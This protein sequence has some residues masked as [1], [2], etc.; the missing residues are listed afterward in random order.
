MNTRPPQAPE[1][2]LI[3]LIA[4]HAGQRADVVLGIG[5]DAAL[6]DASAFNGQQIVICTDTLVEGTHFLPGTAPQSLGHKSLAVNLSDLAAMGAEPR[7]ATLSLTLPTA[8]SAWLEQFM[9]GWQTLA[10]SYDLQLLGGDTT[11]GP[12][13][14]T[15]TTIGRVPPGEALMRESAQPGDLILVTGSLGDAAMGLIQRRAA[16]VSDDRL[17]EQL[18]QPQ[19]RVHFACQARAS[20]HACIDVSDGLLADLTHILD[21][22]GCGATVE[23]ENLPISKALGAVAGQRLARDLALTGGD[24]YELCLSCAP[25]QLVRLQDIA[26]SLSLP[27]TCIGKIESLS[28]LRLTDAQGQPYHPGRMSYQHF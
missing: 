24:D 22:S 23:V 26:S 18:D 19:P 4:R 9:T 16:A 1:F 6:L 2:S 3:D 27:L 28:G 5:D 21:A 7:V 10:R 12:L 15:V 13:S 20:I 11:R 8:G 14:I 25:D 17:T